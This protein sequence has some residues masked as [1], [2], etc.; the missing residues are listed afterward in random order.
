MTKSERFLTSI[1]VD[2]YN[3]WW[4]IKGKKYGGRADNVKVYYDLIELSRDELAAMVK[5]IKIL[6]KEI[7]QDK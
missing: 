3:T 5:M 1:Q 4:K 7:K 6:S 2:V